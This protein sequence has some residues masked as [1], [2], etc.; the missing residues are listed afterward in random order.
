MVDLVSDWSLLLFWQEHGYHGYPAYFGNFF[1]GPSFSE[2]SCHSH[3]IAP[4]VS[5]YGGLAC[6]AAA[7]TERQPTSYGGLPCSAA[8]L[9]ERQPINAVSA[10]NMPSSSTSVFDMVH[11]SGNLSAENMRFVQTN[12]SGH[13]SEIPPQIERELQRG[14]FGECSTCFWSDMTEAGASY[15]GSH[16]MVD[17][18]NA[19]I[20]Y[21]DRTLMNQGYF[22]P[23]SFEEQ[24]MMAMSVS[25]ADAQGRM[26]SQGVM[27]L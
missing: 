18:G 16:S 17:A 13:W 7:L 12:P 25:L 20:P 15:T 6:A 22:V 26:N 19:L 4:E 14:D 9:T 11:R 21:P 5:S 10:A 27:W 3:G 1:P 8:A 24:M 23:E 2:E